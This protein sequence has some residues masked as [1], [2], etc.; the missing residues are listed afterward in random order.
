[1]R[2]RAVRVLPASLLALAAALALPAAPAVAGGLLCRSSQVT[3]GE[4]VAVSLV[5]SCFSPT[6]LRVRPGQTVTWTNEDPYPHIVTGVGG[7]FSSPELRPGR[8]FTYRFQRV[9]VFPYMCF[10]HPGMTGAVVVE[11]VVAATAAG[12]SL[13]APSVGPGGAG[14]GGRDVSSPTAEGVAAGWRTAALV[15]VGLL[16]GAVSGLLALAVRRPGRLGAEP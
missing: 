10:Y 8:S 11:P 3:T 7:S 13:A 1:M 5:G 6:V 14:D 2:G 4:G 16:L 12:G 15:A 9:G